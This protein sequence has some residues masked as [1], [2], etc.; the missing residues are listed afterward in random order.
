MTHQELQIKRRS[1]SGEPSSNRH[2]PIEN[3]G[4]PNALMA[5]PYPAMA[6]KQAKAM[7]GSRLNTKV[8]QSK[9]VSLKLV[10]SHH[11]FKVSSP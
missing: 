3:A 9:N 4:S 7:S 8:S 6:P 2:K 5:N 1:S 10:N 11:Q